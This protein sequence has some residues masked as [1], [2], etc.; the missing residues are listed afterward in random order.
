[1]S[2]APGNT[3]RSSIHG[4]LCGGRRKTPET[5]IKEGVW[6][7]EGRAF[8]LCKGRERNDF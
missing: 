4:T 8:Q 2:A 6:D 1:M 3:Q 5:G 7:R